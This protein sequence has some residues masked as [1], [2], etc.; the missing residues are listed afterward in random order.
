MADEVEN[1]AA[2]SG[3]L[4]K[5]GKYAFAIVPLVA[6]WELV[7][8]AWIVRS[9]PTESDW[10]SAHDWIARERRPGELVASAP[11]WSDPLARLHLGDLI[12]LK[13]AARAD[14]TVYPRAFVATVRGGEHPDFR[15]W[16]VERN[17]RFGG[18][19]VRVLRNPSPAR[20]L[21]DFYEHL[22]EAQVFRVEPMGLRPCP[23]S[24]NVPVTGGGLHQ[25]PLAGPER[26]QCGEGWNNV[27][28]IILEDLGHRGRRCIWSHPV[29]DVPMRTVFSNVPIGAAIYGYHGIAYQAER[30][31]ERGEVGADITLTV[32]VGGREVGRDVHHDGQGWKNFR[33]DTASMQGTQ[34]EVV[35]EATM[36]AARAA[37]YCFTG[38]AR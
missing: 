23:L 34:Q 13:D 2:P 6:V 5:Y 30:G 11:L 28:R 22:H 35:F 15:G 16:T 18:V 10:K 17:Q 32:R 25:G 19:D 27:S 14:A 24:M 7:A 1:K 33:F 37:H 12:P 36:P 26:F 9:V 4:A 3:A 38:D 31:G 21:F 29:V 20:P 8:H